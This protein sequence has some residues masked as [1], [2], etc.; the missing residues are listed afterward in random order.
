M[1]SKDVIGWVYAGLR[2]WANVRG[3]T[4]VVLVKIGSEEYIALYKKDEYRPFAKIRVEK[5]GL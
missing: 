1:G 2:N 3:E 5:C 4:Q